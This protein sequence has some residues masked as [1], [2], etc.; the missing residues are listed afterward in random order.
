MNEQHCLRILNQLATQ[1]STLL[2]VFTVS[3]ALIPATM[4]GTVMIDLT[5]P[6]EHQN[7]RAT[8]DNVMGAFRKECLLMTDTQVSSQ[9]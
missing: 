1:L 5:Q 4:A 2:L 8:N 6:N 3:L 9:A 7:W